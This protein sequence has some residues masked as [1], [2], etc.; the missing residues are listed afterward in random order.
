L[1]KEKDLGD[2]LNEPALTPRFAVN[3]PEF[4]MLSVILVHL[5]TII[6]SL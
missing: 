3:L 5:N 2:R 4:K 1:D 6:A